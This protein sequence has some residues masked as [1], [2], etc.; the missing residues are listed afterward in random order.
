SK[1][2][3]LFLSLGLLLAAGITVGLAGVS[4]AKDAVKHVEASDYGTE[5]LKSKQPV[6][7][8]FYAEWCR[9]CK[10]LAP[11]VEEL[12]GEYQGKVKFVKVDIDKAPSVAQMYGITA[13]PTMIIINKGK[14]VKAMTGLQ[15][16]EKIKAFISKNLPDVK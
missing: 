4:Q 13:V 6:F 14:K 15:S 8:D 16:K 11:T 1:P 10:M 2:G 7:I 5:V 9:P 3:V 12:S